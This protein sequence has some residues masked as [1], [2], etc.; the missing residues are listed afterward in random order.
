MS[1][2][3]IRGRL[4]LG[5]PAVWAGLAAVLAVGLA[6]VLVATMAVRTT[7]GSAAPGPAQAA[8]P[9]PARAPAP[10][11]T[12]GSAAAPAPAPTGCD[13]LAALQQIPLRRRL[14]QLVM[15]GVDPQGPAEA[16]EVVATEQVGGIFIGGD[17]TGL[18]TRGA[19][20]QVQEV[21]KVPV[22]VAVDDEGGRVQRLDTIAG[23]MPSARQMARTMTPRQVED[24][25]RQRALALRAAGVSIDFAPVLDVSAQP[26]DAAI[27]DRS[28][29]PDPQVVAQYAGAFAK[30]LREGGVLPVFK[31]FP[32]HGHAVGDS[33]KGTS[34]TPPLSELQ[35]NDLLPYRTVLG[36]GPDAVM[37][38]HLDVPGLTGGDPA[39]ISPPALALLRNDFGYQGLVFSD[40]LGAMAAITERL[41]LPEAVRQSLAAGVDVAL[42]TSAKSLGGVLDHLEQSVRSGT[43]PQRRVDEAAYRVLTAKGVDP[44]RMPG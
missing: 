24:L 10:A 9:A 42:S 32:G 26:D 5:R 30:G 44:C 41:A 11:P 29:S 7:G 36:Q 21:A 20:D 13:P 2:R 31:H 14:A 19:L 39:S 40:D 43:L 38:G 17:S 18:L 33:H 4:V 27:G 1:H 8:P 28:F 35:H 3:D 12:S 23:S 16:R 34:T 22:A 25:A 37:V 15:V 6:A